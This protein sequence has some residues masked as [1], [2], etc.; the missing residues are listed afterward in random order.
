MTSKD[1]QPETGEDNRVARRRPV[2][3]KCRIPFKE[4]EYNG[5]LLN[6]SVTGAKIRV[7]LP[8]AEGY[9]GEIAVPR[10]AIK[11]KF[12]VV[13]NS[14]NAIGI[15]FSEPNEKVE[16]ELAGLFTSVL[17]SDI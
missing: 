3:W 12:K 14:G 1:V 7:S 13:W 9:V 16:R 17:T 15:E 4:F 2:L 5:H 11:I 8:F 6:L 10:L